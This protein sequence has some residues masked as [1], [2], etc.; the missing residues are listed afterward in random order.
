MSHPRAA[1]LPTAE[2]PNGNSDRR[3]RSQGDRSRAASMTTRGL[4]AEPGRGL[5]GDGRRTRV[6]S[7]PRKDAADS[8]RKLRQNR[9]RSYI[10]CYITPFARST[11]PS[12]KG[13][14][15]RFKR[16]PVITVALADELLLILPAQWQCGE[17]GLEH[18]QVQHGS[19]AALGQ[20]IDKSRGQKR[21]SHQASYIA[22]L[23]P[24]A[25]GDLC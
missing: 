18:L 2:I 3:P 4:R 16:S 6:T 10:I 14:S 5:G 17:P 8:V 9:A 12:V 23:Q 20:G 1:C 15:L 24:F 11:S 22:P 21:Q 13:V 25:L 7:L 19:S